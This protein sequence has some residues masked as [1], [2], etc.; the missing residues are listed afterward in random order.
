MKA[1]RQGRRVL[2]SEPRFHL[3]R[4]QTAR[5]AIL[6]D[7]FEEVVVGVEKERKSGSKLVYLQSRLDARTQIGQPVVQSKGQLLNRSGAGFPD[8]IAADAT[9]VIARRGLAAEANGAVDARE[10]G[11]RRAD[12]FR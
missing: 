3:A 7:L 4:P 8:M 2:R 12:Q 11:R 9:R 5:G 10:R 6:G 1:K